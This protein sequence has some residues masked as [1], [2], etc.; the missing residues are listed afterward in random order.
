M[1]F[2]NP[3]VVEENLIRERLKIEHRHRLNGCKRKNLDP[4]TGRY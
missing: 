2:F 4:W 3:A 1:A